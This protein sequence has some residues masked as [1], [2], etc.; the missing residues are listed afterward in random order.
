[1]QNVNA[2]P[3]QT[4]ELKDIHV[5]EQISNFPIAYGWWMLT[6]FII[7]LITV[8]VLKIRKHKRHNAIK[9]QALKLLANSQEHSIEDTIA[10]LKWS[11]M[12]Y[13]SRA[14]LAKLFGDSLQHYLLSKLPTKHRDNFSVLSEQA[15]MNQYKTPVDNDDDNSDDGSSNEKFTQAAK[16]WLTY[17]LPPK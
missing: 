12:H 13:F 14:E 1:M 5:P 2:L 10:L 4:I 3:A 6:A 17:A 16:L 8:S 9:K 7:V 11:A 15:F